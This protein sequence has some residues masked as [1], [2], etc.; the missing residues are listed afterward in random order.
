MAALREGVPS[1]SS[2]ASTY[3]QESCADFEG[4]VEFISLWSRDQGRPLRAGLSLVGDGWPRP[5]RVYGAGSPK[6]G[7]GMQWARDMSLQD[8]LAR[9]SVVFSITSAWAMVQSAFWW[10]VGRPGSQR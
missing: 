9:T 1:N 3:T 6:P 2:P 8:A 4:G 7:A 10:S 5:I